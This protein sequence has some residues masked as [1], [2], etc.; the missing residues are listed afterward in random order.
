MGER[1]N[2]NLLHLVAGN[3]HQQH[4]RAG[5][6]PADSWQGIVPVGITPST[7]SQ[8][9]FAPA[10]LPL[11]LETS[12]EFGCGGEPIP[13]EPPGSRKEQSTRSSFA[14]LNL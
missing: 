5:W 8:Q 1:G 12:L 3:L 2:S 14:G 4:G 9:E 6:V 11:A 13:G 10:F 7:W